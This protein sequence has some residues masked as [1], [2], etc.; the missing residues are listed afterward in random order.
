V[1]AQLRRHARAAY[2]LECCGALVGRVRRGS[3]A[4][5]RE[6]IRAVPLDNAWA[7]EEG[8]RGQRYLIPSGALRSVERDSEREGL[9]VV[10]FYHSHPDAPPRP[11][12]FDREHAWPWY[13]YLIVSVNLGDAGPV[14]AWRLGDDRSRFEEDPVVVIREGPRA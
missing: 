14:A 2:P 5:P 6:V 13:A 8:V 12:Q 10:G 4:A 1:L 7:R 3:S 9:A 11:S